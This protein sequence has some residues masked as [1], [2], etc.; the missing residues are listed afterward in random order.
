MRRA[1]APYGPFVLAAELRL[2]NRDDLTR[3][4][5][6]TPGEARRLTDSAFVLKA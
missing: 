6:L 1:L 2:D 5:G 3:K 4:L